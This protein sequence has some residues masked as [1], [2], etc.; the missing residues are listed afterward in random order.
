[1][2]KVE[3]QDLLMMKRCLDLAAIATGKTR[4]N[5]LVGAVICYQDRIIGE[6]YHHKHGEPHAEVMAIKSVKD[7]TLLPFSTIYVNLEPCSHFG[8]TPPCA[9]LIIENQIPRVVYGMQDPFEAVA[10]SGL[11]KLTAAGVEVVGPV[12]EDKCLEMNRRFITFHQNKRPYVVLKW[13]QTADGMMAYNDFSSRWISNEETRKLVHKLRANENAIMV[14]TNTALYDNPTLNV[15]NMPGENPIRFAPDRLLKIPPTHNIFNDDA[16]TIL[17]VSEHGSKPKHADYIALNFDS[18]N[19]EQEMLSAMHER[20][21]QSVLIEGGS[22]LLNQF[23]Q[24]NLWDEAW[25]IQSPTLFHEGIP[26]PLL[27]QNPLEASYLG[28]NT[29][30]FYRNL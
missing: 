6:G 14:G 23:I 5:P 28:D 10:G 11:A 22:K 29:V 7:T 18:K 24:K 17:F 3:A 13:A 2:N 16:G 26:A 19:L 21:V 30:S 9:D 12:L 1:M 25:V 20:N 27:N 15:R 8:K 4:P